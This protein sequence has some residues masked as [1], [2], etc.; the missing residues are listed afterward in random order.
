[1][2]IPKK[3]DL[4]GVHGAEVFRDLPEGLKLRMLDGSVVEILANARSAVKVGRRRAG[5]DVDD[6]A[7]DIDA[8]PRPR[9][10][11][12]R[13]LPRVGRPGVIAN[14]TRTWNRVKRPTNSSRVDVVSADVAGRRSFLFADARPLDEKIIV[15]HTGAGGD[16]VGTPDI[17]AQPCRQIHPPR[18]AE[19]LIGSAC[20]CIK[21]VKSTPGGKENT[22]LGTGGPIHHAAIGVHLALT[23]VEWIEPPDKCATIRAQRDHRIR[24]EKRGQATFFVDG[25]A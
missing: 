16:D 22:S 5:R 19:C 12:P 9:I 14:F 8:H 21:R 10:R 17:A 23:V 3:Y 4:T 1:M 24:V 11:A 15:N 13:G 7:R 25:V 18:I 20:S 2:E 6:A